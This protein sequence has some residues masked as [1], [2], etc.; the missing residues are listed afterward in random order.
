[1][2]GVTPEPLTPLV[3]RRTVLAG[4]GAAGLGVLLAACTSTP[5]TATTQTSQSPPQTPPT[6]A[7][8][9]VASSSGGVV[10]SDKPYTPIEFTAEML[11]TFDAAVAEAFATFGVVGASVALIQGDQIVYNKGFGA[12][13]VESGAAVTTNTRFRIGSNA[14]SMTSLLLA[15]YVD[16]GL[17]TWD[18]KVLDLWPAFVGPSPELTESLTLHQLLGMGSGIAEPETIEF[19]AGGGGVDALQLLHTIPYL[20]VIAGDNEQYSYNNTLVAA[21]PYMVMLA[22]GTDPAKLEK[23]Y[24]ADVA[25]LVFGP[26]GMADALVGSDPRP[27]GPD[28]ATGYQRDLDQ[29]AQRVPFVSIGGY[30]PAGSVLASST[31]MAKYLITQSQ[32]GVAPD[33]TVVASKNSVRRTHQPGVLVPPD[34]HNGLPGLLLGDTEQTNYA[35]GWFDEVFNDGQRML[36]H[37]GGIDGFGSLMGFFPEHGV[38]FVALTNNEPSIGGLFNF[39]IQASF[40]DVLFGLNDTIP[41]I[42]AT[43]PPSNVQKDAALAAT[44]RPVDSAAVA[45]YLGL[46]SGGFSLELDDADLALHHDIRTMRVSAVDAGGYVIVNGPS[47]V[48]S[49]TL[50]LATDDKGTRTVTI[51][52][53]PEQPPVFDPVVWLTGD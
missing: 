25:A 4:A 40:L 52:A 15:K 31:D 41:A 14:K 12:R 47:V 26:I 6:S 19:F 29:N 8:A 24:A 3:N 38:G 50:T 49:K 36:W 21:A 46:Y 2:A 5:P 10:T 22:N 35:L 45:P 11:A 44:T 28:F 51:T 20:E 23:R 13:D 9:A 7:P 34:S 1:M 43:V 39:S 16:D 48:R 17:T 42:L 37:A 32:L 30:G 33:G 27:F 53:G 18:T